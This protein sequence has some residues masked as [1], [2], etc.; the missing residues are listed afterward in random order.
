MAIISNFELL[1]KPIAPSGGPAGEVARIVVQGYFLEISNLE[2]RD[3]TLI[4]RTRT[5][6][7][8]ATDGINTE[9]TDTNNAAVFDITQDNL[10]ETVM[11]ANATELIPGKQLGHFVNCIQIPA[12]Q[13]GSLA[14]LPNVRDL[15]PRPGDPSPDL[16]I[17]GY[18][19]L[20]LSSTVD[21]LFPLAFSAPESARI[22][23]SPEHRSTYIDPEFDPANFGTQT[24]LDFDQTAYSLPT[25]NGQAMQLIDTHARFNDTFQ[26]FMTSNAGGIG[27]IVQ[28][29]T[30]IRSLKPNIS[31]QANTA[32]RVTAF[33]IGSV[34]VRIPY[35]IKNGNFTVAEA[36]VEK[37]MNLLLR[38][39]KVSKRSLGSIKS[40][41]K[42]INASLAGDQK[43]SVQLSK[44]FNRLL[45]A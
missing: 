6:V 16:V 22:L 17:R 31:R 13:T 32:E 10:L 29:S 12:G 5:S 40:L 37:V 7:K 36:G 21:S 14:I 33:T 43:A 26:D 38:K 2:A 39:R 3:I 1:L 11:V 45:G 34:P 9:F 25:A 15:L 23:V 28:Q 8:E 20:V 24:D 4:F 30:Q 18:A 19:E 44:V 35:V 42:K 27:R 41:T